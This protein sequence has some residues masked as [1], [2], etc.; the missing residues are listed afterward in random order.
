[1][2]DDSDV[3]PALLRALRH[4]GPDAEGH[5][6]WPEATFVHTRLSILDT[7]ASGAQPMANED[8]SI[9]TVFNGEIYNHAD[10]RRQLEAKGHRFRGHSD[11]EVLAHL[12]EED[13]AD[14]VQRLRGMFAFAIYDVNAKRLLL[15][16]DRFG[17]KPLFYAPSPAR[18]AFA[19]ELNALRLIPGIDLEPDR[20]AVSDFAALFY[21]PAPATFFRGI[22]ALEPGQVME[23]EWRPGRVTWTT[24]RYHRWTLAPDPTLTLKQAAERADELIHIAVRG[25]MESDVPLGS[26]LS[27]GIDSSLVS[28]AAQGMCAGAL[29][30]FNV[31]FPEKDY[32]ETWAAHA[33]AKHI[34]SRH[35][36]LAIQHGAGTWNAVTSLL[37]HAGQPFADT[38]LFAV[39]AVCQQ[40]R[41][42]VTVALSGDGGD[43]AFGGYDISWRAAWIARWQGL[44]GVLR[45]GAAAMLGIRGLRGVVPTRLRR[46]FHELEGADD[47]AIVETL[48]CWIREEEHRRFCRNQG[49]LPVRRHFERQWEHGLPK[50]AGHVERL[51]ALVTEVGIRLTLPNDFLFKVDT[52]SMKESMEVRVPML[53]EDLVDFGLTIPHALKVQGRTGK[54]VLRAVAARRL[55]TKVASKKKWGFGI[56][57]DR[58]VDDA[59]RTNLRATLL[60]DSSPLPEFFDPDVYASWIEAFSAG[61]EHH[62]VSRPGL[63]QRA[64][65]LLAV[66]Q[67]LT[68]KD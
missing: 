44:P 13:G 23:A 49:L 35:E 18:L 39:N 37:Q 45:G 25:Q 50:R 12:Y 47:P 6:R 15:A 19:S 66:H 56:P 68:R 67:A 10:L 34:E 24:H 20:Q 29:R 27:G 36:T 46:R 51:S 33:V 48:S 31:R 62:E 57:V 5:R 30:T 54:R 58:W 38:S 26:M 55:P 9:W 53:D 41:R 3:T 11:T 4:R 65:L 59:F 43:E 14:F 1:V 7:S 16:R 8:E 61:E 52:A 21:I 2:A 22:R 28:A 64:I 32:D 17:I 42:H 40:M 60:E 63:Y